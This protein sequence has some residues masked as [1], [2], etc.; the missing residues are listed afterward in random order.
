MPRVRKRIRSGEECREDGADLANK[1]V[2]CKPVHSG[3]LTVDN[4]DSS[5]CC[6]GAGDAVGHRKDA[7][8]RT[9]GEQ[10]V[11]LFADLERPIDLDTVRRRV[12]NSAMRAVRNSVKRRPVV[13]P[14]VIEV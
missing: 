8:C 14:V 7:E 1:Q 3:L 10:H 9:D 11:A 4:D 12:R 2:I 13:L 5:I 6:F